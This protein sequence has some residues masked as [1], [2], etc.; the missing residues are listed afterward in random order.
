MWSNTSPPPH[1]SSPHFVA[2]PI[3]VAFRFPVK[4]FSHVVLTLRVYSSKYPLFAFGALD[5]AI[6]VESL[7]RRPRYIASHSPC[8]VEKHP[9]YLS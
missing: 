9:Y 5:S 2:P 8:A 7:A 4:W 1:P 3:A 6:I